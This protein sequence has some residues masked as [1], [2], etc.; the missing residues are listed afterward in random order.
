LPV[1]YV[2]SLNY[3]VFSVLHVDLKTLGSRRGL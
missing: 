3:I 1:S 2:V